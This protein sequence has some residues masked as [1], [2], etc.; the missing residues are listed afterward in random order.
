MKTQRRDCRCRSSNVSWCNVGGSDEL[1]VSLC[2]LHRQ[3]GEGK[4]KKKKK[5]HDWANQVSV[6]RSQ[7]AGVG[8]AYL[9]FFVDSSGFTWK[10]KK[11]DHE[12]YRDV[13]VC[14]LRC[15]RNMS[16]TGST[17]HIYVI[18]SADTDPRG[19]W[20]YRAT[21]QCFRLRSLPTASRFAARYTRIFVFHV[22]TVSCPWM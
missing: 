6:L 20:A 14:R 4:I 8:F 19:N 22:Y 9:T 12:V 17:L 21:C 7:K 16:F 11:K 15:G 5:R 3:K 10:Q 13:L 1:I 2:G 18:T